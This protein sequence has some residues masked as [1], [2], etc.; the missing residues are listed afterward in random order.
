MCFSCPYPTSGW[1]MFCPGNRERCLLLFSFPVL[2][3]ILVVCHLPWCIQCSHLLLWASSCKD[4][5][6][7]SFQPQASSRTLGIDTPSHAPLE[8]PEE[9]GSP[10]MAHNSKL[11]GTILHSAFTWIYY[12]LFHFFVE[13]LI[14]TLWGI[15]IQGL[16][17]ES[18]NKLSIPQNSVILKV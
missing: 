18:N 14:C 3:L 10:H 6:P 9:S 4:S 8:P 7:T 16:R 13:V 5:A 17:K 1:L 11:N 12:W 2:H 15:F